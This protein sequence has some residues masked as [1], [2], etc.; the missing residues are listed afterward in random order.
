MKN[1]FVKN[2]NSA[3]IASITLGSVAVGGLA[4]L[5]ISGKGSSMMQQMT[6]QFTRLRNMMGGNK[7]AD[8]GKTEDNV[9][10]TAYLH[11]PHKA[12]K[13]DRE[14]LLKHEILHS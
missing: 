3:L 8:T 14:A 11:E 6:G 2:D 4:Y 10:H 1:P 9:D 12:P 5:L 7:G 13:T